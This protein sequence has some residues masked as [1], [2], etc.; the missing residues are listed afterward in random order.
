LDIVYRA[1]RDLRVISE[2]K[3]QDGAVIK[4]A[5]YDVQ[6]A[7][8]VYILG[9]GFDESNSGLLEL[10][11]HLKFNNGKYRRVF[12]TNFE[13]RNSVN[14]KASKLFS[15][16]PEEL[17]TKPIYEPRVAGIGSKTMAYFEKSTRDVYEALERD[18]DW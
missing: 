16:R 10:N 17:L 5:I 8:T 1:S 14:K 18:F 3:G 7:E 9:Y 12:F 6:H 15:G 4:Q 2:D 11:T 13:D